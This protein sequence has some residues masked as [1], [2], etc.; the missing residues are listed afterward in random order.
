MLAAA[1]LI[2][3]TIGI[4]G[5]TFVYAKGYSCMHCHAS[6]YVASGPAR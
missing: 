4:G 1:I 3:L 2:G 6:V 5:Y